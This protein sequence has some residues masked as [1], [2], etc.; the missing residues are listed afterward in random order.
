MRTMSNG[1]VRRTETE[2]REILS[3]QAS[4]GLGPEE[5]C[6]KEGIPLSSFQRWQKKL[7]SPS[8]PSGFVAVTT[9]PP[10]D[11]SWT[12]EI[13]LPNGCTLRLEG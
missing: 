6:R 2:W 1:R 3:R 8:T 4:S 11:S 13:T 12:M 9:A 10:S 5:F 7:G